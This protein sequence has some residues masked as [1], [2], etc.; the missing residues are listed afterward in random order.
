M[1]VWARW[2]KEVTLFRV[3]AFTEHRDGSRVV[4]TT[5]KPQSLKIC[6]VVMTSLLT[7]YCAAGPFA[8]AIMPFIA[9]MFGMVPS[10]I[11]YGEYIIVDGAQFASA[12]AVGGT[13]V[14]DGVLGGVMGAE[15][16][17]A[18]A[19]SSASVESVLSASRVSASSV[20][21]ASR[22][23]VSSALVSDEAA[24]RSSLAQLTESQASAMTAP[25]PSQDQV[26]TFSVDG[27][28][29]APTPSSTVAKPSGVPPGVPDYN[30]RLC[31]EDLISMGKANETIVVNQPEAQSKRRPGHGGRGV[32]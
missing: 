24:M 27:G 9:P 22:A 28:S 25:L 10:A 23:S 2:Y 30:F 14:G 20:L 18:S 4:S 7:P 1:R 11:F 29:P 17:A 21:S 12:C 31:Q 32:H 26:Y 6:S 8:A 3:E 16:V 19:A 13:F 5:M 15:A